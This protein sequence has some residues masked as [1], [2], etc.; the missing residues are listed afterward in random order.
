MSNAPG[1]AFTATVGS[2][3][4]SALPGAADKLACMDAHAPLL[5]LDPAVLERAPGVPLPEI[6]PASSSCQRWSGGRHSW[7]HLAEGG[8][9]QSRYLVEPLSEAVAKAYVLEHHYSA[10]YP[11]A[12]LRYGLFDHQAQLLGVAVFGIPMSAAVLSNTFPELEP[13]VE[14][15]ELSRL[16]LADE[17]PANA[18]SWFLARCFEDLAAKGLRGV[19]S[20]ADPVPRVVGGQLLFPGHVGT[21]YQASNARY[22]GRATPRSLVLLPDGTVLSARSAQKVRAKER[23]HEHVERL[24]VGLGATPPAA[25]ERGAD[26]LAEALRAVGATTLRH[27]GNH[28]YAFALGDRRARRRLRIEGVTGPY[29]K[30]PG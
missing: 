6:S 8:F 17:V 10:S 9:D 14:S 13:M 2:L 29:P 1:G 21:I 22:C 5:D 4:P 24:L 18:E 20:F 16:V 30:Q 23:G 25:D 7:R 15:L 26:W 12:K 19:V 28:R 11:A 3:V 27:R